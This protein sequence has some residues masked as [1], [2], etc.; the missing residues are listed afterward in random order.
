LHRYQLKE[1]SGPPFLEGIRSY[2]LSGDK[3][4]LLY[5][6][7]PGA[8]TWGIIS[9]EKPGKVGEGAINVAQIE[10][11]IDPRAEWEQI[12][13]ETWRL[14]REHFYDAKMHGTDW[15]AIYEKYRPFVAHVG[16]LP[17]AIRT[18]SVVG[19]CQARILCRS[20]YSEQTTR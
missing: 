14:Q 13:R 2:A 3:K 5:Q 17:W 7:G 8:G 16:H 9:S 10:M 4:K 19:T 1:R 12:Y 6:A 18:C 20:D 15:Q 11:Q